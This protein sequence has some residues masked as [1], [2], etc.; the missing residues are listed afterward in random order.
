MAKYAFIHTTG[1]AVPGRDGIKNM[2]R[3]LVVSPSGFFHWRSARPRPE[4]SAVSS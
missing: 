1:A 4:R 2:C 3:W